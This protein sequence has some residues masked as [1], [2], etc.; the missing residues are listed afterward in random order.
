[1]VK[2]VSGLGVPAVQLEINSNWLQPQALGEP[3]WESQ[4]TL[5]N[6]RAADLLQAL[7]RFIRD[8]GSFEL[9]E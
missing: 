2:W 6:Q 9:V 1:M 5:A 8:H 7:I 3:P 4:A